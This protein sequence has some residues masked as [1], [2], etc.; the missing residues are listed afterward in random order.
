M[1]IQHPTG[2]ITAYNIYMLSQIKRLIKLSMNF[3]GNEN[4]DIHNTN[5]YRLFTSVNNH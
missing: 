2:N 5:F 4:I 3:K 1:F